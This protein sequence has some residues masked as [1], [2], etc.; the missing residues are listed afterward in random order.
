LKNS[1]SIIEA[2]RKV[3]EDFNKMSPEDFHEMLDK[4]ELGAVGQLLYDTNYAET[5]LGFMKNDNQ[6]LLDVMT[7][8]AENITQGIKKYIDNEDKIM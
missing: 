8:R 2:T 6:V 7:A 4:A 5:V 3:F 1:P